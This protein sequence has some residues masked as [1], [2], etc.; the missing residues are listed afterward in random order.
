VLSRNIQIETVS[1]IITEAK[2]LK[3]DNLYK[4]CKKF[5]AQ[6]FQYFKQTKFW[7][8]LREDVKSELVD[9]MSTKK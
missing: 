1:Y 7:V 3:V 8:E 2:D 5:I 9:L 4:V 6:N